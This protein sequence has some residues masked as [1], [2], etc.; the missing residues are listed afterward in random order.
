LDTFASLKETN[1]YSNPAIF[2]AHT[3]TVEAFATVKHTFDTAETDYASYGA[4]KQTLF[5]SV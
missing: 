3:V 2:V 1:I 4:M 5:F